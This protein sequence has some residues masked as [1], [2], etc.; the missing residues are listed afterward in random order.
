MHFLVIL[1]CVSSVIAGTEPID[2]ENYAVDA[3]WAGLLADNNN[4]NEEREA[5]AYDSGEWKNRDHTPLEAFIPVEP[6]MYYTGIIII[7]LIKT[8]TTLTK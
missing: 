5:G 8:T 7:V 1:S 2:L 3:D 4:N 6:H